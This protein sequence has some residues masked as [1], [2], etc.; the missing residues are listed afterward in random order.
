MR[1][2][3]IN[4][5]SLTSDVAC[6]NQVRATLWPD[7]DTP[8]FGVIQRSGEVVIRML[9]NVKQATIKPL[10]VETAAAGTLLYTAEYNIYSRLEEWSYAHKTVN[11]G[12]GE[13]ARDEDGNGFHEVHIN[14]MEGFGSLL[15][16][17]L[18]PH[19]SISQEKLLCYLP[20]LESLHNIKKRG[21]AALHSLLVLLG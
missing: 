9:A 16:S 12:T 7:K 11:H 1:I 17:W 15:R 14:T 5:S 8:I 6:F 20:F 19:R 13:Y 4:I 18:R 21:K 3:L 10:I 2:P